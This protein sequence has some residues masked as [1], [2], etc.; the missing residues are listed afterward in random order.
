MNVCQPYGK[1]GLLYNCNYVDL[2]GALHACLFVFMC[3]IV[4]WTVVYV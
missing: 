4:V 2:Q 3:I 1:S